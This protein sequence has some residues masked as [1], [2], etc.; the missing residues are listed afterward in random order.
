MLNPWPDLKCH[1]Y[2]P[3]TSLTADVDK[4]CLHALY[5]LKDK[6]SRNHGHTCSQIYTITSYTANY[7]LTNTTRT[8][9]AL[10]LLG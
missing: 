6:Q 9:A 5:D 2:L 8:N 10:Y 4:L 1:F 7:Y 3:S